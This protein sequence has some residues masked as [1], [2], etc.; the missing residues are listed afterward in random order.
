MATPTSAPKGSAPASPIGTSAA[1]SAVDPTPDVSADT[2]PADAPSAASWPDG[3]V[4]ADGV[5][6]LGVDAPAD[7]IALVDT[8]RRP[9]P[10]ETFR[11]APWESLPDMLPEPYVST[12]EPEH[13]AEEH[14]AERAALA[15]LLTSASGL[16]FLDVSEWVPTWGAAGPVV[17]LA[18]PGTNAVQTYPVRLGQEGKA[19]YECAL[20]G[21]RFVLSHR[22]HVPHVG[23]AWTDAQGENREAAA[24]ARY[25][26]P[27]VHSARVVHPSIV[28]AGPGAVALALVG[29]ARDKYMEAAKAIYHAAELFS[30]TAGL[31]PASVRSGWPGDAYR[32]AEP[33]TS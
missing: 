4:P 21:V 9:V 14:A 29:A 17:F 27:G 18:P 23:F 30:L 6:S 28:E 16:R 1:N 24:E 25:R 15:G 22:A 31:T 13:A 3:F 2:S 19:A 32:R 33:S 8:L 11:E 5:D 7:L 10:L 26:T 12:V 20:S